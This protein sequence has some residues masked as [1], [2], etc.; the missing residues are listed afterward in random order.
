MMFFF[1]L[2]EKILILL[3]AAVPLDEGLDY[4][5]NVDLRLNCCFL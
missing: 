4:S 1:D 5:W 2:G 3:I